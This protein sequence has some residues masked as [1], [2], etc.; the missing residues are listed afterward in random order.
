MNGNSLAPFMEEVKKCQAILSSRDSDQNSVSFF[1]ETIMV[2]RLSHQA[3][4]FFFPVSHL[5]GVN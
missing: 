3:T 5:L 4:N 2:D 1:D